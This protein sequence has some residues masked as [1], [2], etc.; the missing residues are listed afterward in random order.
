MGSYRVLKLHPNGAELNL[1]SKPT[2]PIIRVALNR[3]R[4][5]PKEIAESSAT[6]LHA[7]E[8]GSDTDGEEESQST[9]EVDTQE[10]GPDQEIQKEEMNLSGM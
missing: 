8:A 5:C 4:L 10:G 9:D 3:I 2:A 1:T 7:N 6:P